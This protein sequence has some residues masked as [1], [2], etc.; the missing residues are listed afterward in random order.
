[1]NKILKALAAGA[2]ATAVVAAASGAAVAAAPPWQSPA[3]D[4]NN[5]GTVAF[6]DA[7]GNQIT[8]GSTLTSLGSFAETSGLA[9]LSGNHKALLYAYTPNPSLAPGAWSGAA[10]SS[11]TTWP[12]ASAPG[13][14]GTATSPVVS[15]S[16]ADITLDDYSTNSFPN[17]STAAGYQNVYEIRVY[18]TGT[19][20]PDTK[21]A[22]ADVLVDAAAHTW[23]QVFGTAAKV[24]TS[25]SLA[26]TRSG[27]Q[28]SGTATTLT[29]TVS[30]SATA[31]SVQFYDGAATVGAPVAVASGTA[32][33][34]L[35][36][37]DGSH[38]Y[39]A[40]FTPSDLTA[41]TVSP[42]SNA[43]A[44]TEAPAVAAAPGGVTVTPGSGNAYAAQTISATV[45][46]ASGSAT[47]AG[48]LQFTDSVAGVLGSQVV[49][50]SGVTA[51]ASLTTSALGAGA[52]TI[53]VK[54][55][56]STPAFTAGPDATSS[57][58]TL[59]SVG[60]TPADGSVTVQ[61]APGSLTISTPYDAAHPFD[62]GTL[63]L[64]ADGT[65]LTATAH[66]GSAANPEQ[67]IRIIDNRAG[68]LDWTASA[69]ATPF[70]D[71]AG[72]SISQSG[73]SLT[74]VTAIPDS[75]TNHLQAADV[76]TSAISPFTN[77]VQPFAHSTAG[78]D[79]SIDVVGDLTLTAP[80][81]TK[82]GSYTATLT[83]T[84]I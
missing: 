77:A 61:V 62:L 69:L 3:T 32:A 8:S 82:A 75:A 23:T 58:F 12:N 16:S 72:D 28:V 27:A 56:P 84:L 59:A 54:F 1:M 67:G 57:P 65:A 11:A 79:G 35:T 53:T 36:P 18:D 47:P 63:A 81:G 21:Y 29:A 45:T 41:F 50:G 24:G 40:V 83:F 26:A 51:S 55:L 66:F 52:H 10:L 33:T 76:A 6:F 34:T 15:E 68:D 20:G 37:T 31:G 5:V 71:P 44:I 42:S 78:G 14:L 39:T 48:S 13:A 60:A 25:V 7:S 70:T 9:A 80:N 19:S 73:L 43:I 46:A 49:S 17:S 30:P 38:S 4:P 74:N 2:G 22:S 64:N